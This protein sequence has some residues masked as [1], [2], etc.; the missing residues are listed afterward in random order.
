MGIGRN[1]GV[2]QMSA[3][4]SQDPPAPL[5]CPCPQHKELQ[6]GNVGICSFNSFPPPAPHPRCSHAMLP[7]LGHQSHTGEHSPE[8]HCRRILLE[9]PDPSPTPSSPSAS[10]CLM[11]TK[12]FHVA[13]YLVRLCCCGQCWRRE[14]PPRSQPGPQGAGR[15]PA[16]SPQG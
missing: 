15:A 8:G 4:S 3:Y 9:N 10:H 16:G 2:S 1:A 5:V 12:Y 11:S 14:N 7:A 13:N 6:L